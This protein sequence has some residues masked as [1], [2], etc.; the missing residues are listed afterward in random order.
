[1]STL[2][3]KLGDYKDFSPQATLSPRYLFSCPGSSSAPSGLACSPNFTHGLR[4]ALHSF[5]APRLPHTR[6][7]A[8]GLP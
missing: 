2:L 7:R 3:A 4:R 8:F 5:A 1:M 6:L